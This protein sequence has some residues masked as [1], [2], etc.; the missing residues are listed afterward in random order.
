MPQ[1]DLWS[2]L[3][4][5]DTCVRA[6]ICGRARQTKAIKYPPQGQTNVVFAG[7]IWPTDCL[8]KGLAHCKKM[9]IDF[10]DCALSELMP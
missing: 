1:E 10:I 2:N 7:H 9:L 4:T 3:K 5:R 8:N 6:A